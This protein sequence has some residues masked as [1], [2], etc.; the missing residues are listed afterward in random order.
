MVVTHENITDRKLAE[1]QLA[2]RLA[3]LRRWQSVM[4][5]REGR[6]LELKREVN[7]LLLRL[8]EPIRYRSQE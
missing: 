8:G 5:G 3:E 4:L 1:V 6:N 2:E 7:E